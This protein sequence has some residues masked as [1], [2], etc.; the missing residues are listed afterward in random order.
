MNNTI[1]KKMLIIQFIDK[2]NDTSVLQIKQ[3]FNMV[4]YVIYC[5]TV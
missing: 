3:E 2:H 1:V 5:T 4:G